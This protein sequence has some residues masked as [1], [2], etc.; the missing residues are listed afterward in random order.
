MK[1]EF[2]DPSLALIRTAQ[3]H[4][5]G[6]PLEI[7]KSCQKKLLMIEAATTDLTL[8]NMNSLDFKKVGEP[9]EYQIRLNR[10]YRMKFRFNPTSEPLTVVVTFIGAPH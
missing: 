6:L 7:V 10:K 5:L 1:I 2:A 8:R 4:R 9:D 3:A